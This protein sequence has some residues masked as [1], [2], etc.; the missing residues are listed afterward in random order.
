MNLEISKQFKDFL[1]PF[2]RLVNLNENNPT[3]ST[4]SLHSTDASSSSSNRKNKETVE[5]RLDALMKKANHNQSHSQPSP[6]PPL[7]TPPIITTES[8]NSSSTCLKD[9]KSTHSGDKSAI[10]VKT[11]SWNMA[12]S[13]VKGD[14]EVLLGHVPPFVPNSS[15]NPHPDRLPQLDCDDAHPY[16]LV[17]VAGQECP[18]TSNILPRGFSVALRD[19]N[20][21]DTNNE[22]NLDLSQPLVQSPNISSNSQFTPNEQHNSS[23]QSGWSGIL[24]QWFCHGAGT[25]QNP[26]IPPT[27][28]EL[29][30]NESLLA[31]PPMADKK[32]NTSNQ[33]SNSSVGMQPSTS[34]NSQSQ[35]SQQTTRPPM[36]KRHFSK[37]SRFEKDLS[38]QTSYGSG[39]YELLVKER[40]MGI[41]IAVF[42]YKGA[43][44]LIEG[45]STA[46]VTAGLLGGRLG[47]KG[48]VG[49]SVKI[50]DTRLL[51]INSHL[52][53]HEHRLAERLENMQK[54]QRSLAV[55]T[56]LS[57]NDP[58]NSKEDVTERFDF[59]WIMGDLNMRVD[60]TRKHADWLIMNKDYKAALEF[61]QLRS[62]MKDGQGFK[63]FNEAE[64][65]FPPTFKYDVAK[66]TRTLRRRSWDNRSMN[67]TS[68][69]DMS[70]PSL[71]STAEFVEIND[72]D[73]SSIASTSRSGHSS[74]NTA[75]SPSIASS[76]LT[77]DADDGSDDED[78]E[79]LRIAAINASQLEDSKLFAGVDV[80]KAVENVKDAFRS[81]VKP[82]STPSNDNNSS[83]KSIDS[84]QSSNRLS[85]DFSKRSSVVSDTDSRSNSLA[86]SSME[87]SLNKRR[88]SS[89]VAHE[90]K[91]SHKPRNL[92]LDVS[93]LSGYSGGPLS[94]G[95]SPYSRLSFSRKLRHSLRKSS[96]SS[97]SKHDDDLR[98]SAI[99]ETASNDPEED[100]KSTYD[101]SPKQRVPS[102]CDRILWRSMLTY[103]TEDM[104]RLRN[105]KFSKLGNAISHVLRRRSSSKGS[106]KEIGSSLSISN[107]SNHN[108]HSHSHSTSQ[109]QAQH[110]QPPPP[111]EETEIAR[112]KLQASRS[113]EE[114]PKFSPTN[115]VSF[116]A[117]S[118]NISPIKNERKEKE[119]N[120]KKKFFAR[121]RSNSL[122]N[123]KGDDVIDHPRPLK[124]MKSRKS[125]SWLETTAGRSSPELLSPDEMTGSPSIS[126]KNLSLTTNLSEPNTSSTK[127]NQPPPSHSND[128]MQ[129]S[130]WL[131]HSFPSLFGSGSGKQPSGLLFDSG[132]DKTNSDASTAAHQTPVE[133]EP[134]KQR[135]QVDC[136]NYSSL[137][138]YEMRKLEGRSDHR[139]VLGSFLAPSSVLSN[140]MRNFKLSLIQLGATTA[141]KTSNLN[142][143]RNQILEAS[144][145]NKSDVVVLPEC[146]NSPY[147]V[148]YFEK[149]AE[150]IPQPGH[151]HARGE[152][153]ESI[154]MLSEAAKDAKVFLIG[155]SIPERE[156]STGRIF[157][158]LTV[159]DDHGNLVGKHRKLH[160]FDI[161][162]PGKVS[163]K[164]SETLTAGSDITIVDSPFGKIGLGICYDVRFPEM[165]MIAARK[166][167]VAM[168]YPGAFNTT[169][170]PL[171]WELLQRARAVDNQFYV[172]MCSPARD[173]TAEYHAWGH[174]TVVNP[175]GQVIAKTDENESIVYADI[176]WCC[177]N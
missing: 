98:N 121:F 123:S 37:S 172:A 31:P 79:A 57:P 94:A 20:K 101:S 11:V 133:V 125:F 92:S 154:K 97:S 93:N 68:T 142:R 14:L 33:S 138:D 122:G 66:R 127:A 157:N 71:D 144:K 69:P 6:S 100:L 25:C 17:V 58:K 55:D 36:I 78:D 120:E 109:T 28:G 116:L 3:A 162:I 171:H 150:P 145:D 18:T 89:S 119:K 128:G 118:S 53:A 168:I 87:S 77:S 158:T 163:F 85:V 108:R 110:L 27:P 170:G 140:R 4:S 12:D 32:S 117:G 43:K 130:K 63:G 50:A 8:F 152:L 131:V 80:D 112:P 126:P 164:E 49:A 70:R 59:T 84:R 147:G 46:V 103:E 135:G 76:R 54:I 23:I 136:I 95:A 169:T 5:E 166:G 82:I 39:P 173:E 64:I 48:A 175:S 165:A 52:A 60:I 124:D 137:T 26:E 15:S 132:M 13:L 90:S 176:G 146:F 139:P 45:S 91:S 21:R 1:E 74:S 16:H 22:S 149:Y 107:L 111:S 96:H 35:Q 7:E 129:V 42:V 114:L 30:N 177:Y 113:A 38:K 62:V 34:A 83:R 106:L 73:L 19:K 151:A 143:A 88:S 44:H 134:P 86:E 141:D 167:C 72:D 9:S 56:F 24:E 29:T 61:D 10:K 81:L 102:W 105:R 156:E 75:K 148:K 47:N 160:L 115:K 104:D 99:D 51:F 155:G 40:L 159:Y 153:S 161:N 65:K 67:R 174:S 41:Y 2:D